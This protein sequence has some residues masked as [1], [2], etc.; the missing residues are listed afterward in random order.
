MNEDTHLLI[1]GGE[2]FE[3]ERYIN[4][5]FVSSSKERLSK[6]RT[7]WKDWKFPMV[8]GDSTYIPHPGDK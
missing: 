6:A 8:E 1:F 5:N 2:A 4:W 3:E 7:D